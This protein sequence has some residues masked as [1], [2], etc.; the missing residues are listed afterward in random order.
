MRLGMTGSRNGM[1]DNQREQLHAWLA[2]CKDITEAHHGDCKGADAQFHGIM[3][4]LGTRIVVHPPS[5]SGCR[6]YCSSE[7]IKSP[8]PFLDRNHDI[9]NGSDVLL[10]FP[11]TKHEELRSGTWATI[12]YAKKVNKPV[13]IFE[14]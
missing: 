12:R 4:E 10:A 1:T 2:K 9:V 14:P 3:Q 7:D 8:R 6:A 13:Y 11:A 5:V